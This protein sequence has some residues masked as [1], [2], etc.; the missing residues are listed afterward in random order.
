MGRRGYPSEFRRRVLDLIV[1]GRK[2]N[3][4]ARDLGSPPVSAGSERGHRRGSGRP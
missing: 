2:V 3:E 1:S 4:V